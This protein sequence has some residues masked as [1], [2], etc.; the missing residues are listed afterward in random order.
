MSDEKPTRTFTIGKIDQNT[1]VPLGVVV[2]VMLGLFGAHTWLDARLDLIDSRLERIEDV[3]SDRWTVT[4]QRLWA[5]DLARQNATLSVP[6]PV[7]HE[8]SRAR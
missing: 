3:G 4:D 1:L 5:A 2:S 7:H 8:P 6:E